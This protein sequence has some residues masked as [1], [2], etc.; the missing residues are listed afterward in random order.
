M[1]AIDTNVLLY[2][3][4][5]SD[6]TK[7]DRARIV[8][9]TSADGVLLWQVACEFV[10]AARKIAPHAPRSQIWERLGEIRSAFPLLL[11]TPGVLERAHGIQTSGT[12]HYWD[13][14]I[15]AVCIEHG[16]A[17]L[18]SED[19]PGAPISGLE[20]VNPFLT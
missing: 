6:P 5:D 9:T 20:I 10:A 13:C 12:H 2:A 7:R 4:S 17:R 18:L 19:V 15:F 3:Y 14:L 11:P 8:L 1:L 16:I